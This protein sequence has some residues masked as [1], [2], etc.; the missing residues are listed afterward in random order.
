VA[1][2]GAPSQDGSQTE[3]KTEESTKTIEPRSDEDQLFLSRL[4]DSL[5]SKISEALSKSVEGDK[6]PGTS[7]VSP[8]S[9]VSS[10]GDVQ[11]EYVVNPPPDVQQEDQVRPF[12]LTDSDYIE[13]MIAGPL[14]LH[15]AQAMATPVPV[16][17]PPPPPIP[18]KRT[19][20][21]KQDIPIIPDPLLPPR[22]PTEYEIVGPKRKTELYQ[23]ISLRALKII[24]HDIVQNP[25]EEIQS[26]L[27]NSI[28]PDHLSCLTC[29]FFNIQKLS[30]DDSQ[31]SYQEFNVIMNELMHDLI[32]V[33]AVSMEDHGVLLRDL[34]LNYSCW[35][36]VPTTSI[37]SLLARV[38]IIRSEREDDPLSINIWKGFL[39]T[40]EENAANENESDEDLPVIHLQ[41]LL[42]V[43]HNFSENTRKSLLLQCLSSINRV[44][45]EKKSG[46]LVPPLASCRLLLVF[47]YMLF[48][49]NEMV[50]ELAEQVCHYIYVL[51]KVIQLFEGRE[52]M[53]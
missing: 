6:S 52:L 45:E 7:S 36:L 23:K 38:L 17:P 35:P 2:L 34:G 18:P 30:E 9:T 32:S 5:S 25:S 33:G 1:L 15:Y 50:P 27:S 24:L 31:Q 46:V 49:F 19:R 43:W 21:A 53:C 22:G 4:K 41:L 39:S 47:H 44:A 28:T 16:P 51:W 13:E 42:F 3:L 10:S 48:Q 29:L 14:L 8:S 12:E 37:L 20:F 26:V 11:G 40:L